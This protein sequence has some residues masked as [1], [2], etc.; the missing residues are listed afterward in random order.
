[1]SKI[2]GSSKNT[3]SFN[4]WVEMNTR[5]D[6]EKRIETERTIKKGSQARAP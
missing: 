1:M 4:A 3:L 2:D 6:V 5:R